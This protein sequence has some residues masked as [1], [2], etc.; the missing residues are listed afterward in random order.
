MK[1]SRNSFFLRSGSLSYN[2]IAIFLLSFSL[3]LLL[4]SY[5]SLGRSFSGTVISK[6]HESGIFPSFWLNLCI[7][8][9]EYYSSLS[10]RGM[11]T[12]SGF[13]VGVSE[14]VFEDCL[15]GSVVSKIR[16][17]PFVEVDEKKYIDLGVVWAIFSLFGIIASCV[18]YYQK[19]PDITNNIDGATFIQE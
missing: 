11:T 10:L 9:E 7:E 12:F 17:S 15:Y 14:I 2:L 5:K 13:R 3:S 1:G 19:S 18:I 8:P 6:S 16:F 4:A